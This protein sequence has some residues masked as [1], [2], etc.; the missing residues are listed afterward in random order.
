MIV[1]SH[2]PLA[3]PSCV[4]NAQ[5]V[6]SLL[7][8]NADRIL[9]AINGH[10]HIDEFFEIDGVHYWHVNSAAYYWMG[11]NYKHKN[12]SPEIH[13]KFPSQSST[14][15]YREAHPALELVAIVRIRFQTIPRCLPTCP[16]SQD[17]RAMRRWV[18]PLI[19]CESSGVAH[20]VG[21]AKE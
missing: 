8:A 6:Q 3:G 15:P 5:V 4:D 19:S 21:S 13:A 20:S 7:A 17:R 1:L 12:Y 9:V 11:S 10:T 18:D 2:Q 14:C 16:A